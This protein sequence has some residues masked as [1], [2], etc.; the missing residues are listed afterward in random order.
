MKRYMSDKELMRDVAQ[1]AAEERLS[2]LAE[3]IARSL[4]EQNS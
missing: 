1:A 2:E 3:T 4:H